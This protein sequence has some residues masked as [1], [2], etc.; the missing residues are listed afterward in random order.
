MFVVYKHAKTR[1]YDKKVAYCLRKIQTLR[2]NNSRIFKIKNAKFSGYHFWGT[3]IY[4]EILPLMFAEKI[5][6]KVI[7]ND[8]LGVVVG[9]VVARMLQKRLVLR[10]KFA[11][12][13]AF[14]FPDLVWC[15]WY[16]TPVHFVECLRYTNTGLKSPCMFLFI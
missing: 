12:L 11:V 5:S 9:Y 13:L 2:I 4:K 15:L 3:R 6:T 10:Q 14:I 1:K 7:S 8:L 16:S